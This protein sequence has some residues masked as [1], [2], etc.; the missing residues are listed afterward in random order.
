MN[1][2]DT[3]FVKLSRSILPRMSGSESYKWHRRNVAYN[4]H[5][6]VSELA[7]VLV[8]V[9]FSHPALVFMSGQ[10][11]SA[12]LAGAFDGYS[13]GFLIPAVL[14]VA[15]WILIRVY[16][17]AEKLTEKGPIAS[18]CARDLERARA[19]LNTILMSSEPLT[20]L[21][22]LQKEV[23]DIVNRA[24]SVGAW[25][26]AIGPSESCNSKA[27]EYCRD[28]ASQWLDLDVERAEP[29]A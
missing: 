11:E 13:P 10:Q 7:L 5:R 27:E 23:T 2:R 20:S 15:T 1:T 24:Y 22:K 14:V 19:D 29:E 6:Y 28:Y 3:V 26:W 9:G 4:V 21:S 12:S 8:G 18:M 25:P 17:T 16:V